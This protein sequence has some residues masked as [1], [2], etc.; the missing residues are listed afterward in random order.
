MEYVHQEM[1]ENLNYTVLVEPEDEGG[2]SGQCLELPSAISQGETMDELE[3]NMKEAIDL[4]L[5]DNL[6]S[7]KHKQIIKLTV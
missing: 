7:A 3:K 4:V 6:L 5:Q 1:S 2:F